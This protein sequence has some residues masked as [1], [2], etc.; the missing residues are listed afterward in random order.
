MQRLIVLCLSLFCALWLPFGAAAEDSDRGYIQG[1]L[2]DALS[3]PGRT[4]TLTGFAGALSS[5]AT[6]ERITITDPDGIWFT[7]T[8][9][10]LVWRRGALLS[11][12]IEIDEITIGKIDLPRA[13]KSS[14]TS[15]TLATPAAS[16]PFS[17]PQLPVSVRIAKMQIAEAVL[18]ET[19]FGQAARVQFAGSAELVD[20]AGTVELGLQRL[21]QNGVFKISGGFG[22]SDQILDLN[23]ELDEPA[24]GIAANL[25]SLPGKP[26]VRLTAQGRDPISDFKADIN[27][28]TDGQE[29]LS[30]DVALITEPDGTSRFAAK[31]RGDIAPVFV[32]DFAD[33]LGDAVQLRAQGHRDPNGALSL[34]EL[35]LSA[36]A[37]N[38][39]GSGTL[40]PDGWPQ[41]LSLEGTITPPSG[42]RVVLPL[43]GPRT[44]IRAAVLSG[45]FDADAGSQWQLSGRLMGLVQDGL[46]AGS[47]GFD[48]RGEID[49]D[50]SRVTGAL[51]F[52]AASLLPDNV[53]IARAIGSDLTGG[54][55]FDWAT[56]APLHLRDL[57]LSGADYGLSGALSVSDLTQLDDLSLTPDITLTATDLSRFADLAGLKLSGAAGLRISGDVAPLT[58]AFELRF[59]GDTGDLQTG[60]TQFDPLILGKGEL[61]L[62]VTRDTAGLRVSPALIDTDEA[63]LSLTGTLTDGTST[64]TLNAR[65]RDIGKSLPD[66][67]GPATLIAETQQ[68]GSDWLLTLKSTLPGASS[69]TFTGRI[70]EIAASQW[71]ASGD[72]VAEIG[73]LAAFSRLA[74]QSLAGAAT[75]RAKGRANLQDLSFD[76]TADG[77]LSNPRFGNATAET[78]LRGVSRYALSATRAGDTVDIRQL[79][80]SASGLDA[81]LS[82]RF[83]RS[84]GTLRYQITLPDL[85]R[86][87]PEFPGVAQVSGTASKQGETWQIDASGTGPGGI[88]LATR[89]RVATD[90]SRLDLSVTGVTP[91]AVANRYLSGQALS[92]QA[93]F[94][95]AINGPPALSSVTGQVT[96][97]EGRFTTPSLGIAV[98]K[99]SGPITLSAS[100]AN[101]DLE[102]K[103]SSGGRVRFTG[104]VSLE[105]PFVADLNAAL[106]KVTLRDASLY[107]I[108]LGGDLSIKGPLDGGAGIGGVITL[109]SAELRLPQF[110]PSYSA[111]EG[112]RHLNPNAEVK[113]TL[114]F[115]GL[116]EEPDSNANSAAAYPLDLT[117]N[118]PDKLFIRGRGLDAELGGSLQ[119]T[120]TSN[121][122][123][124]IGGFELIRG[125]L[126]LLG[127]RLELT[128]GSAY[129]RGS[130]DPVIDFSATSE[131]EDVT[132]S[133]RLF[134]FASAPELTVTS[135]PELPQDEALSYF[136]FG[137][138]A[139][140]ISAIQAVQLAAAIRTLTGRG[141]LGIA[142]KFRQ[143]LGLDNLDVGAD[144]NGQAQAKIGKYVS[145]NIYT[146]VTIKSGESQINLNLDITPSLKLRGR[147]DSDGDTG[148]GLFFEKDY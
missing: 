121:D 77:T 3:A 26:S 43:P 135:T 79:D 58:G 138:D 32:P 122:I 49:P 24:D 90:A 104:P 114:R 101:L 72:V 33:F 84:S 71:A 51:T 99:I 98:E 63:S 96:L 141:G 110:N 93:Q 35:Y 86:I 61:S 66:L 94:D 125:R 28:A 18:G 107:E 80:L 139:T 39:R 65:L 57:N 74:G 36:A 108:S 134:G 112:L 12:E 2:E 124:P 64:A 119:L 92:G 38:L 143:G 117:I 40:G 67:S 106:K 11:G 37:L 123:I 34:S 95:L 97:S 20:G 113:R 70:D 111:L 140:S 109:T 120:G 129:L 137:K 91:L 45:D 82:G 29:R 136:L 88:T 14:G 115:A 48:G 132:V 56:G 131:V 1:L 44:A 145:D 4:V 75:V 68:Q 147:L 27:L 69:A 133:L 103:I 76:L 53:P 17:L 50:A 60:L 144:E 100:R 52:D 118:A 142:D 89:G 19:L 31:L 85:A 126:D 73:Q 128:Q 83:D 81:D 10:A 116:E 30:G 59:L 130:F 16:T 9:V 55:R 127:R 5:R 105:P 8:D 23:I 22:N 102:G 41:R 42:E 87:V 54:L 13:P 25:L 47:I 21:D 7:A 46:T 6:M 78:L 148:I 146:D 62:N 15:E